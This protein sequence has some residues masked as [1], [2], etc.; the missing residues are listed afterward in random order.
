MSLIVLFLYGKTFTNNVGVKMIKEHIKK[1]MFAEIE[2]TGT[3]SPLK[4]GIYYYLGINELLNE[5][6]I[7]INGNL[8]TL[9]NGSV[10]GFVVLKAE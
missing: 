5:G 4:Y 3:V 2:K 8:K 9:E 6:K 7:K 10:I 1:T